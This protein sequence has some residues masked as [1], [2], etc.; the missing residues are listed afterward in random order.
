MATVRPQQ[1]KSPGKRCFQQRRRL[2]SL[3]GTSVLSVSPHAALKKSKSGKTVKRFTD[4]QGLP[5]IERMV[6]SVEET[7]EPISTLIRGHIPEWVNGNFLRNGPGKFEIG[8]QKWVNQLRRLCW[9]RSRGLDFRLFLLRQVQPL[10]RRD[11]PPAPVQ[12]SQR[13]GDLQKPLPVQRQLPNQQGEQ[14]HHRVRVRHRHPAGPLQKL[15]PKVS[16]KI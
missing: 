15:L 2:G 13:S 16:D 1:K 3:A 8:N 12:N 5:C 14:P 9:T 4:V 7:P 11:G 10:V 6:S